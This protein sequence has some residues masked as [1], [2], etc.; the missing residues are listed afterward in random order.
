MDMPVIPKTWESLLNSSS[1]I[2]VI[3]KTIER[4]HDESWSMEP[5]RHEFFEMVYIKK[6]NAVFEISGEPVFLGPNDIIII[7]PY[8]FHKF[9]VNSQSVCEFIVLSFKFQN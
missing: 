2:P 4:F 9:S 3:V 5:N 6:G 8:Q 7:K 1:F